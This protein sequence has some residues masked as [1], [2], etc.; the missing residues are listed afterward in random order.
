MAYYMEQRAKDIFTHLALRIH[1]LKELYA[2]LLYQWHMFVQISCIH[3]LY[4]YIRG[5][6]RYYDIRYLIFFWW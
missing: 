3:N 1:S 5:G 4:S 2:Y 6:V